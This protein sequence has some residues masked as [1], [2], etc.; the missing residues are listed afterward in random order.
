MNLVDRLEPEDGRTDRDSAHRT[1]RT[2]RA[3]RFGYWKQSI[4]KL[5]EKWIAFT[6][7]IICAIAEEEM[8]ISRQDFDKQIGSRTL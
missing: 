7:V 4:E 8:K 5:K 3:L 6:R 1:G 2:R